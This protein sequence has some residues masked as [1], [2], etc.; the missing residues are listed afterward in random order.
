MRTNNGMSRVVRSRIAQAGAS[1]FTVT[2]RKKSVTP[3][4]NTFQNDSNQRYSYHRMP[5]RRRRR[6]VRAVRRNFHMDMAQQPLQIMSQQCINEASALANQ[7]NAYGK[8]LGGTTFNSVAGDTNDEVL[9]MFQDAYNITG[10]STDA[11]V[12]ACL[13]YKIQI[14]SMCLDMQIFNPGEN[15]VIADIYLLKCRKTHNERQS[16]QAHYS[17]ALA[18]VAAVPRAGATELALSDPGLTPFDAPDFCSIW[19]VLRKTE[20]II[21]AGQTVTKQIRSPG[22][23]MVDGRRLTDHPM[24]LKGSLALLVTFHGT[25]NEDVGGGNPGLSAPYLI[26]TSQIVC[27][28]AVPPGS[29]TKEAGASHV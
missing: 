14:K 29:L 24:C 9:N 16:I 25:P 8:I 4:M 21:G 12:A 11:I 23:R 2:K 17:E 26:F 1:S 15:G 20:C 3:S 13:P 10:A 28:Y 22:N 27:H 18:D 7:G 19:K 5:A 6:W